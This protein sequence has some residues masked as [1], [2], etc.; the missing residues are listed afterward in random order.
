MDQ[1]IK[2]GLGKI[3]LRALH[4]S[5]RDL[6]DEGLQHL[7]VDRLAWYLVAMCRSNSIRQKIFDQKIPVQRLNRSIAKENIN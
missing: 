7:Y 3:R 4:K 6:P 5:I 2:I 1:A